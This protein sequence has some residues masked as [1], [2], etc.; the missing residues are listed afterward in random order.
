MS[1][2]A[3]RQKRVKRVA[4][5]SYAEVVSRNPDGSYK[6]KVLTTGQYL[7][8]AKANPAEEFRPKTRVIINRLGA[9]G[10]AEGGGNSIVS[11]AD[12][13]QKG[14]AGTTR[15]STRSND[16]VIILNVLP[17]PLELMSG[18]L[19]KEQVIYGRRFGAALPLYPDAD[20][21]VATSG[22]PVVT[23]TSITAQVEA[24][25]LAA[26]GL[27]DL[28]LG[29]AVW[30]GAVSVVEPNGF[31]FVMGRD[32]GS[33]R[34]GK[35]YRLHPESLEILNT[36]DGPSH[37]SLDICG[38]VYSPV[39]GKIYALWDENSGSISYG[40]GHIATIDPDALTL[41]DAAV[42]VDGTSSKQLIHDG[43]R[44]LA[45]ANVDST[46]GSGSLHAFA[47]DGSGLVTIYQGSTVQSGGV[48]WDGTHLYY[49]IR[50]VDSIRMESDGANPTT[51]GARGTRVIEV[52][53][54]LYVTDSN[55][56]RVTKVLKSDLSI[57][58]HLA[59]A[60]AQDIVADG[61][62][63]VYV[64]G[65]GNVNK[66]D[67]DTFTVAD[68][69]TIANTPQ[70]LALDAA[71]GLLYV[72][73]TGTRVISVIDLST[74]TVVATSGALGSSGAIGQLVFV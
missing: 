4:D 49:V 47:T 67:L 74:F 42:A 54:H 46:P 11:R 19:A 3:L 61:L 30:P 45:V 22:A 2:R 41:V 20:S 69:L 51:F 29:G 53:D 28:H 50:S 14:L 24:S 35:I 43:S 36:I 44:L 63:T 55:N 39:T 12:Q 6:V 68:T 37:A 52:G 8:A 31:L 64:T 38:I 72:S 27:Y 23:A 21:E 33:P 56:N 62:L 65:T 34:V 26:A 57:V 15:I 32:G 17:S 7:R 5:T 59:I 58:G 10:L 25:S 16:G 40:D 1:D 13:E 71:A 18:G 60:G 70:W 9:S 66:V 73:R 48:Y